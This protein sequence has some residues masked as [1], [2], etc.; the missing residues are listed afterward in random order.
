MP[1]EEIYRELSECLETREFVAY[2]KWGDD[3]GIFLV[4]TVQELSSTSVLFWD[5][6]SNGRYQD[7]PHSVPLRLIHSLDRRTLYLWRLRTLYDLGPSELEEEKDVRRPAEVRTL[8]EEA[9]RE[10]LV[11]SIW[12]SVDEVNDYLVSSVGEEAAVLES[13]TDGGPVDGRTIM[14]LKRIVRVR[15]GRAERDDA[16]VHRHWK[17]HGFPASRG[18]ILPRL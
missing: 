6:D 7:L 9:V 10:A 16:R 3:P 18:D 13:V 4:G 17:Q 2:H 5:V 12:T 1:H 15:V 8:L 11:V 14:R